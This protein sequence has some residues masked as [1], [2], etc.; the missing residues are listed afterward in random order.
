MNAS[1]AKLSISVPQL[2][3]K[4]EYHCTKCTFVVFTRF[5]WSVHCKFANLIHFNIIWGEDIQFRRQQELCVIAAP[6]PLF[7][8][9]KW[10]S[11]CWDLT[12]NLGNDG[13][14]M[15][16]IHHTFLSPNGAVF[17]LLS[18]C[19]TL[20]G[21]IAFSSVWCPSQPF[22]VHYWTGLLRQLR[23]SVS[24]HQGSGLVLPLATHSP[25]KYH[26]QFKE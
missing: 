9:V 22:D 18:R 1:I 4:W 10:D 11:T 26:A 25:P 8:F 19:T 16:P 17:L 20:H 13:F 24:K 23:S 7:Y 6:F 12:H 14:V 5:I 15:Q 2:N 3:A 21:C